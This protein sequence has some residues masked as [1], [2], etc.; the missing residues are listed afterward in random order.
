MNICL[1]SSFVFIN[2]SFVA[3]IYQEYIYSILFLQLFITSI[4]YHFYRDLE[5][6]NNNSNNNTN[7]IKTGISIIDKISIFSIFLYGLYIFSMKMITIEKYKLKEIIMI[8][9][10]CA[11]F[12]TTIFLF[13]YGYYTNSYCYTPD[14]KIA[15]YYHALV[16]LVG[17]F[18]HYM[19]MFL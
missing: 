13:Y 6:Y 1:L 3:F 17:S 5:I 11:S 4:I 10:I 2:H 18:G 16:H 19:I 12:L 7:L 9:C 14:N 8:L 15:D